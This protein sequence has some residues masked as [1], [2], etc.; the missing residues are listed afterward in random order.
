MII[1]IQST[2]TS[3]MLQPKLHCLLIILSSDLSYWDLR[4]DIE[5]TTQLPQ[6]TQGKHSNCTL[7][8]QSALL[9]ERRAL[10][11]EMGSRELD[12]KCVGERSTVSPFIPHAFF[13]P[14]HSAHRRMLTFSHSRSLFSTITTSLGCTWQPSSVKDKSL[15]SHVTLTINLERGREKDK[16]LGKNQ[17]NQTKKWMPPLMEY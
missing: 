9:Q 2:L 1:A 5:R 7:Q 16:F 6:F 12:R 17:S 11:C 4:T 15:P 3:V 13:P 8:I 10:G 14:L